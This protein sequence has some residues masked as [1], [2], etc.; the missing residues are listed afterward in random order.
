MAWCHPARIFLFAI[1]AQ[2]VACL[3][4]A[5]KTWA[6]FFCAERVCYHRPMKRALLALLIFPACAAPD[7][8]T[9]AEICEVEIDRIAVECQDELDAI[10]RCGPV[11]PGDCAAEYD[12]HAE[13]TSQASECLAGFRVAEQGL[14]RDAEIALC[15]QQIDACQP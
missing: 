9:T 4:P 10:A 11:V 2:T 1:H 6:A 7:D 13:C 5:V 14:T 12:A 3:R 15:V 8:I